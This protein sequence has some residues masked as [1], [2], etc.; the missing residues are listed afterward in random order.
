M[1]QGVNNLLY[2]QVS[3]RSLLKVFQESVSA[4]GKQGRRYVRR[5]IVSVCENR[6]K[7]IASAGKYS[8]TL[9]ELAIEMK[10]NL[11]HTFHP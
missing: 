2:V 9:E 1:S 5:V 6:N 10:G 4:C 11:K 8:P 7:I 3:T